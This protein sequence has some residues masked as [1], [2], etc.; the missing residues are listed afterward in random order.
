[1]TLFD[2]NISPLPKMGVAGI[3]EV[4]AY[5]TNP[6]DCFDVVFVCA[7]TDSAE[8]NRARVTRTAELTAVLA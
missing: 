4:P 5:A 7:G 6:V 1:M 3:C 8:R 2:L